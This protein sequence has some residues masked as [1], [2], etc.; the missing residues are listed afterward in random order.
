MKLVCTRKWLDSMCNW[1]SCYRNQ[2]VNV[3]TILEYIEIY[4]L[5]RTKTENPLRK[6]VGNI[7][8]IAEI[9]NRLQIDDLSIIMIIYVVLRKGNLI[10]KKR[11]AEC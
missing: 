7:W 6:F 2:K 5:D 1:R 8:R 10:I 9:G 11:S 4:S 3:E